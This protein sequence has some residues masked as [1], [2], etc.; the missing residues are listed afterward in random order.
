MSTSELKERLIEK[1]QKTDNENLLEEAC[2]LL[3]LETA[4]IEKYEFSDEEKSQ[5]NESR[6][7]IKQGKFLTND[8]ANKETDEWLNK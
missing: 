6:L 2:R 5:V 7:Q 1:I 4:E 8:E 3:D